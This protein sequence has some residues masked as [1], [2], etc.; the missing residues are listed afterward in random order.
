LH[1]AGLRMASI[2]ARA[3][4]ATAIILAM[5]GNRIRYGSSAAWL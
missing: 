4:R 3:D 1:A 5:T 2:P